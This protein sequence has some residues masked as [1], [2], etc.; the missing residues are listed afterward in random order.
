MV[1]ITVGTALFGANIGHG[2]WR[3]LSEEKKEEKK[4]SPEVQKELDNSLTTRIEKGGC[5][6]IS[7]L[8]RFKELVEDMF[9][10]SPEK[11]IFLKKKYEKCLDDAKH[12]E[13]NE[14][15]DILKKGANPVIAGIVARKIDDWTKTQATPEINQ[16]EEDLYALKMLEEG[17]CDG[18]RDLRAFKK[19][20]EGVFKRNPAR[21]VFLEEKYQE[22]LEKVKV[23]YA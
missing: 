2:I 13:R 23:S 12:P 8:E 5:Y 22:C 18:V 20:F 9:K 15:L 4:I 21:A 7:N 19:L 3:V 17:S 1:S 16:K 10:R 11:E 6:D 14:G